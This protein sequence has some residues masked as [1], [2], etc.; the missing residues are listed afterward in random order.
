MIDIKKINKSKKAQFYLFAA[1]LLCISAYGLLSASPIA[2]EKN[3]DSQLL[4][5]NYL[6]E[7][8]NV[9]NQALYKESDPF[10]DV[11]RFTNNFISYAKTKNTDLKIA[12]ILKNDN[13]T[14][15]VN[16]L[17]DDI[18]ITSHNRTLKRLESVAFNL[19][20]NIIIR[21]DETD[22]NYTFI[23]DTLEF[24]ALIIT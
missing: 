23:N 14:R 21:Y 18:N 8:K 15:V 24:K 17:K 6:F 2:K 19:T 3:T 20:D 13:K 9:I 4:A 11:D 12:Y 10:E 7:A 5:S 1:M 22:Y 16:Y